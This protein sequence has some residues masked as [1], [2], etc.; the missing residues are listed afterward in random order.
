[1]TERSIHHL[2][3][4]LKARVD[5]LSKGDYSEI[6]KNEISKITDYIYGYSGEVIRE[7]MLPIDKDL[8][9]I[10]EEVY[11]SVSDDANE[12]MV[13]YRGTYIDSNKVI[14]H[15]KIH[16]IETI[17]GMTGG[18]SRRSLMRKEVAFYIKEIKDIITFSKRF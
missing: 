12:V 15:S 11:L 16:H 9:S 4:D 14:H 18:E 5:I 6:R 13:C 8:R 17:G 3:A 7:N 10:S 2:L 1:M